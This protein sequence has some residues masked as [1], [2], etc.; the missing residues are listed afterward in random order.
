[1]NTK[2]A[3]VAPTCLMGLFL[4][5]CRLFTSETPS[6]L[7][8]GLRTN[9][10]I[11]PTGVDGK[12][13]FSWKMMSGRHGAAQQAYRIKLVAKSAPDKIIWDSGE[14][15]GNTS[16]GINYDGPQLVP[17]QKY[18]WSVTVRDDQGKWLAPVSANFETGL[19][20][21]KGWDGSEWISP[22]TPK[23]KIDTAAFRNVIKN[24]KQIK[25]A[26][27]FVTGLGV[28]E[29]YVNGKP[30]SRLL[31]CGREIHD[32]LKPGF[33]A[34]TKCR[35]YFS[36]DI[37]HLIK[38]EM[39][40]NNVFSAF[41]TQGWWRDQIN[42]RRGKESAF[43]G[44]LLVRY[45]DGTEARFGTG[46]NWFAAYAGP[47][48]NAGIFIGET[49]DARIGTDWMRGGALGKEW[50]PAKINT[51]FKGEIRAM[52]GTHISLRK[53]LELLPQKIYVF[54][55]ADGVKKDQFGKVKIL[56]HYKDGDVL[57]LNPG[58]TMVVDL[59]QNAAGKPR[60]TVKGNAGTTI[61]IRHAEMLNDRMGLKSRG[62]DGPE[63][64]PYV[65]NLRGIFAGINY[66]LN[67][68][69]EES[70]EPTFTF[71]G[72]RYLGITATQKVTFSKIRGEIISSL[73]IGYDT[74]T[75]ETSNKSINQLISN[76]RWG[77]YSNY[78]SVP[79]DCPQRNERLGWTADTQVFSKSAAY[80][81]NVYGFLCKWMDDMR[82]SQH[83]NGAFPSVAPL[84]QYGNE[85]AVTGWA[86]AGII[87]PYTMYKMYGDKTILNENYKAMCRYMEH[88]NKH[89]GPD[90]QNYGDWLAY[91]RND[92]DIKMYL[93]ACYYVWDARMMTH[94]ARA[95]GK[96]KDMSH[97]REMG[98]NA[99]AFFAKTYLNEDGTII[100]KYR[101]QTASLFALYLK[102]NPN[103]AA[104]ASTK[105]DLLDNIKRHGDKLQTGF[106]GTSILMDALTQCGSTD[107][108]YTLL[109]QRGNPSWLYSVDQGATTVWERWNSYTLDKGFGPVGMNSFN[110]YAYGA[111]ASW[112]YGT[113]A[114]I[115]EDLN[116]P[117]FKHIILAPIP[118]ERIA[119]V[120]AAFNSP[121]GPILTES[122][123]GAI[124]WIYSATIPAN[125]TATLYLPAGNQSV[126]GKA[127]NA[128]SLA[129][130]GV[131]L[132]RKEKDGR[133]VLRV[134]SGTFRAVVQ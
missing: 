114:G 99:R 122:T 50:K 94:I 80:N 96:E 58:E 67:G 115:R 83:D 35:H 69:E 2:I 108:A 88:V 113:M 92:M 81:A 32:L 10:M 123:W 33:T 42:G 19:I 100:Q 9:W 4:A 85:G 45:A 66:T 1:M 70:Y 112:M 97:F 40:A 125:T 60:F 131:E 8:T 29:A 37:T 86:D 75:L 14:V 84:A 133:A 3:W 57:E 24:E 87:V 110:H 23:E 59:G 104:I 91:E 21:P 103:A 17:A 65:Q 72:Y 120:K 77:Q 26:H 54:Q 11:A 36:Y 16:V 124:G 61:T 34:A 98:N 41:V 6:T 43:R 22:A 44:Q 117:G 25:S 119:Q 130:D 46:K 18:S 126:N 116:A 129:K 13:T 79:T 5:G 105:K 73:P 7:T 106:L 101:C 38:T 48:V 20:T 39:G 52:K 27:W 107:V 121:Y 118:D 78:L 15:K 76:I 90:R 109:L 53:D 132:I 68:A 71:F 28:F 31:P 63:G 30:I 64:S 89:R 55:D 82:D 12:P 127:L 111:V 47:I 62:N 134:V 93:A 49:Y 102:L 128:V 51:E 74:G 56:R 95:L